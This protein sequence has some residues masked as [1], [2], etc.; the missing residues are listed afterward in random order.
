[1]SLFVANRKA[2]KFRQMINGSLYNIIDHSESKTHYSNAPFGSDSAF[3]IHSCETCC[4]SNGYCLPLKEE[5]VLT[6]KNGAKVKGTT[7][8]CDYQQG[9]LLKGNFLP[10]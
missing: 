8:D 2:E 6:Q 10:I 7:L 3:T 4:G 5:K 1:M 9:N